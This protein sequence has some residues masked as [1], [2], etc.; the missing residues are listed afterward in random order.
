MFLPVLLV[1]SNC[2]MIDPQT[3]YCITGKSQH[4]IVLP[5]PIEHK[6]STYA[7]RHI[8]LPA[9]LAKLEPTDPSCKP[10]YK[11]VCP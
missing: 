6:K 9:E 3:N 4:L 10:P 8:D 11:K 2:M 5:A 7:D 1:A